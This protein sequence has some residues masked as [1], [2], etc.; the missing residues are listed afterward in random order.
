MLDPA[1]ILK[2][3]PVKVGKIND[4]KT[5]L[6]KHFGIELGNLP[7]L[8]FY[9]E[10][11]RTGQNVVNEDDELDSQEVLCERQEKSLR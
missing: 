6:L 2:G 9:I 11:L 1:V 5:L 10:L 3:V 4:V 8:A 7:D